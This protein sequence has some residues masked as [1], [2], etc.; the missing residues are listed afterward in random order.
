MKETI[1]NM[2]QLSQTIG[3]SRPTLS[4]FFHSPELV[5][6]STRKKIEAALVNV[7]YVPNFFATNMNRKTT[8]LIGFVVPHLEDLFY[9]ALIQKVE[10]LVEPLGY[11]L[12]VQNAHNAH[13]KEMA[14]LENLRSMNAAGAIIAPVGRTIDA[15]NL[16]RINKT[17]PVVFVDAPLP[18]LKGKYPFVGTNHRQTFQ[19]LVDY[20]C[21]SSDSPLFLEMPEVN[22]NSDDRKSAYIARMNELGLNPKIIQ[23]GKSINHDWNFEQ[24]AYEVMSQHFREGRYHGSTI[25]CAND[26]LAFGVIKAVHDARLWQETQTPFRVKVAGHDDHPMSEFM[27]PGVTT[28]SQNLTAIAQQATEILVN[29][30]SENGRKPQKGKTVLIDGSLVIRDSA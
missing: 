26:R 15:T 29:R 2:T 5:R 20:L 28:A 23:P 4:K 30:L 21:R 14:A 13:D 7:D 24:Y 17:L 18:E 11:T 6:E 1:D 19:L 27:Y 8:K 3:V 10:Q 16:A 9:T 25:L 12:L 22:S